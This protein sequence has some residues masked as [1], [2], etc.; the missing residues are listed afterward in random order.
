MEHDEILSV[1]EGMLFLSGDEG[2]TVK[3]ISSI[4]QLSKK[5]ATEYIDE[6]TQIVNV[7]SVKGFELMNFGG[8]FKFATLSKHHEYYQKMIENPK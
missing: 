6:L 1:I 7:R 3:Q 2:L 4:L 5:E 8:V